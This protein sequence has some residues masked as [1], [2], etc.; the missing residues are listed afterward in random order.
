[1]F[2]RLLLATT[3]TAVLSLALIACGAPQG[4]GGGDGG[5]GT[6]GQEDFKTDLQLGTGS[7]GGVYFPLGQELANILVDNI[8]VQ[9]F[10]VSSVETGASVDNL[11]QI[12]RGQLQLGIAQNNTA[13]QAVAGEGE[14]EGGAV[15][16]AGF[17]G[18]LYPEAI[19]IIT[20][21]STG[22][23]SVAD[24]KGKRVA[25]GPPGG[26]TRSAAE[27]VL[28]AYGIQDGDFQAFEEGFGTAQ[29]KLQDGNLDASIEVVGVPSS[30]ISELQATTG[31]VKLI[32]VEGEAQQQIADQSGYRPFEI[33]AESYDFL[34]GPVPTVSAFATMFG[35]TTQI[36]PDLGYEITKTMYEKSD[37]LTLAQ[38]QFITLDS[39]LEGRGDLPLHPG[40][41]RYFK[42]QGIL[43]GGSTN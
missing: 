8:D 19:S 21:K 1:M 32:P 7:V 6:G 13:Q 31:Q 22:I 29:T 14:F 9:G 2:K 43:G 3:L 16:N 41:E 20:L 12:S 26:A 24:L 4:S 38:K 28:G 5:G 37:Q 33:P 42:E 15:N 25:I 40:A 30:S 17:M 35:S 36:S 18:Q 23:N 34:N 39:A 11:A 27:L 10:N